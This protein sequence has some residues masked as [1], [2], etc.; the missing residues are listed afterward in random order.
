MKQIHNQGLL[1]RWQGKLQTQFSREKFYKLMVKGKESAFD[2]IRGEGWINEE[3]QMY[4]MSL[5]HEDSPTVTES[6]T[7]EKSI[8]KV[9]QKT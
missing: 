1:K 7:N 5:K 6:V 2:V 9:V 3:L 8:K 4:Q